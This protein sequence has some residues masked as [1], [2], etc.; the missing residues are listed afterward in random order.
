MAELTQAQLETKLNDIDTQ[1]ATLY[2]TPS[3]MADIKTLDVSIS[4]SQQMRALLDAR[5]YYQSL[6][7]GIPSEV[8]LD[9][10]PD[11]HEPL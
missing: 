5:K 8:I 6:L 2:G 7:D 1:I 10:V 9:I 3:T 4:G 11:G